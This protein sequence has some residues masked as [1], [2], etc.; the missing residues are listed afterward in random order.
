MKKLKEK[1]IGY[2]EQH[3]QKFIDLG[4]KLFRTPELG[5]REHENVSARRGL[6][7]S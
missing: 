4:N 2:L 1:A 7:K 5:F 6:L 3:S